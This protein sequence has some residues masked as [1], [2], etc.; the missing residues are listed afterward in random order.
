MADGNVLTQLWD[1]IKGAAD[2]NAAHY[3]HEPI[4][5]A[6]TDEDYPDQPLAAQRS[7]LRLWLCEMF[8]TKS[9]KWFVEWF[10]AVHSSVKLKFGNREGVTLSRVAQAPEKALANGVLLNYEV[11]PLVPFNGGVVEIEAALLGLKGSDYLGAAI[12]V[13]QD[14]SSLVAPPIGRVL[15]V[16]EKVSSGMNQLF[17]AT[18]GKVHLPFHQSFTSADG[19]GH[20]ELRPG[21]FAVILATADQVARD[22]LVV[23]KG[24]LHYSQQPG[25]EPTPFVGFDYLLF[26]IEGRSERDDWR[27][28]DIQEPLD[29]AIE[30]LAQG[31][32]EEAEAYKKTALTAAW[33]SPDLVVLDRGRVVKAIKEEL[34]QVADSGLGA[35]G[36]E[37]RDLNAI[38]QN[39]AVK[40]ELAANLGRMTAADVFAD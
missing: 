15:T 10:P 40:P 14:F 35:V 26:R 34:A 2:Q 3:I 19:G 11:S 18:D 39:R 1:L 38:M 31:R 29:K 17:G 36:G 32:T 23:R 28:Q 9:R 25:A 27:L 13:L 6:R 16:A 37:V 24:Q 4:P 8:L 22:R 20:N 5:K 7:Y 30:A 33:L 12:K 21:Y